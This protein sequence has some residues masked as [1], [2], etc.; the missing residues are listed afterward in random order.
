MSKPV[1][2]WHVAREYAGVAEAGGVKDVVRGLAEAQARAGAHT[3]VVI[4]QYGFLPD[5]FKRGEPIA[6]FTLAMPDQDRAS[7]FF[8]ETIRIVGAR[9]EG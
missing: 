1:S 9:L 3:S 6:T 4:P 2:V 7:A 8:E 5:E